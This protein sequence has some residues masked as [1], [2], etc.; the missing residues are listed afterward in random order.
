MFRATLL[1]AIAPFLALAACA[2]KP[3]EAPPSAAER[4][5]ATAAGLLRLFQQECLEQRNLSWARDESDRR[6]YYHCRAFP[7]SLLMKEGKMGDCESEIGGHVDWTT[8]TTDSQEVQIYLAWF[9]WDW[10]RTQHAACGIE[11]P[12]NLG[13]ALQQA[14]NIVAEENFSSTLQPIRYAYSEDEYWQWSLT[15]PRLVLSHLRSQQSWSLRL[16]VHPDYPENYNYVRD[17]VMRE[18]PLNEETSV[19][20]CT[21]GINEQQ[22]E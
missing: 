11:V 19:Y 14:A 12:E 1:A 22:Q 10:P 16:M 18:C 8:S 20:E 4:V 17:H 6:A 3:R 5:E 21:S 9:D 13:P 15:P 2:P 7:N